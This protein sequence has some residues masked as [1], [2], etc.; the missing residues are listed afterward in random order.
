MQMWMK[1]GWVDEKLG[2]AIV[3][4]MKTMGGEKVQ[5]WLSASEAHIA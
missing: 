3:E 1:M 5:N 4:G 2:E